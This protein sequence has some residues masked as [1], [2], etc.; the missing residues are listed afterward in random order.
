MLANPQ[1]LVMDEATS[2]LTIIQKGSYVRIY[3]NGLKEGLYFLLPI[4]LV[5]SRRATLFL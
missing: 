2:A 5:R 1:L 3:R 4:D